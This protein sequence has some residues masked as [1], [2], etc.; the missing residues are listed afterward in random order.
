[1]FTMARLCYMMHTYTEH[2]LYLD[3]NSG[4]ISVWDRDPRIL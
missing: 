4:Q 3:A 2:T 1:M